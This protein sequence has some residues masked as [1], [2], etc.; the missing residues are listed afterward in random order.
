MSTN[1]YW[2]LEIDTFWKAAKKTFHKPSKSRKCGSHIHI[3]PGPDMR[4]EATELQGIAFGVIYYESLVNAILPHHR[5]DN[6]YCKPNSETSAELRACYQGGELNLA[7][8]W[9]LMG[10]QVNSREGLRDL[11]QGGGSQHTRRVLWNFD[12]IVSGKSGTVEFRGASGFRDSASTKQ[13]VSFVVA[14]IHL[15]LSKV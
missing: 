1:G 15:C 13:W 10:Q 14:F 7:R 4:W 12:N 2:E 8:V 3:S 6:T 11:M 9:R 5:Q